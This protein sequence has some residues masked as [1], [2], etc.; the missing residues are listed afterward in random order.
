MQKKDLEVI[1][2]PCEIID[3]NHT[4]SEKKATQMNKKE[5]SSFLSGLHIFI[6]HR[7]HI[8]KKFKKTF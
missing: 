5:I 4:M 2:I 7:L 8:H 1:E 6:K 3:M